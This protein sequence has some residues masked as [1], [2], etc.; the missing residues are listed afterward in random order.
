MESTS[1]RFAEAARRL[2][3]TARGLGLAVPSFRSPPRAE[4]LSRALQRHRDGTVMVSVVVRG[5]PW[6][7]VLGDLV[8]GVVAANRLEP[9]AA[10][11]ARDALWKAVD[12]DAATARPSSAHD[13]PA[14][15]SATT[16]RR[17]AAA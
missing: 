4:G 2:G 8:E 17:L 13:E 16:D 14:A 10:A 15:R 6:P 12:C 3:D 7:A 9:V 1:L 5:R 11:A